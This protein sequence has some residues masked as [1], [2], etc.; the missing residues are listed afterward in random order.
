MS[1]LLVN[2]QIGMQEVKKL[3]CCPTFDIDM[4]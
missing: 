1:N 3:K 4:P 2:G